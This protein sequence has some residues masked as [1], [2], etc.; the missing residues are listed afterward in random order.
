[1]KRSDLG[2]L[3][4]FAV[5]AEELS[6]TRAAARLGTSQSA[7]SQSVRRLESRLGLR[8]LSRTTRSMATTEAGDRLLETLRPAFEDIES[9]L[10]VLSELRDR[11]AGVIRISC[12]QHAAR[13]VLWPALKPLLSEYQDI[14]LELS[15]DSALTDIVAAR[16][17]AGVRLGERVD[18]DMIAMKIG[19]EQR[20]VVVGAPAYFAQ[21][22]MPQSP[23]ELTGH[24]CISIRLP[25]SGGLYAWE[26]GC[27]GR[28]LRVRV[29]GQ[30]V[31]NSLD[32]ALQAALDGTGLAFL[33]EDVVQPYLESGR[34][35]QALAPWCP[36]FAGYHLYSPSRRQ[37]APAFLLGLEA[38]RGATA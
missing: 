17:D 31:V 10:E 27:N 1:M 16:F 11:P 5:I 30:L 7:L 12:S 13:S 35:R 4:A 34:L 15:I 37:Q 18:K 3:S 19:P 32:M 14:R 38:L 22:S 36:T 24:R 20:L 29:D 2:D 23:D 8:L 9:K 25:S 6:F 21:H 33:F 28:E 26:L